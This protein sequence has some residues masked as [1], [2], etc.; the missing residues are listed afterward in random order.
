M[1]SCHA[2]WTRGSEVA[3]EPRGRNATNRAFTGMGELSV[4]EPGGVAA[5]AVD[6]MHKAMTV[7]DCRRQGLSEELHTIHPWQLCVAA[8]VP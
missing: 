7:A 6:R 1:G 4:A 5:A 3:S 8:F 2:S